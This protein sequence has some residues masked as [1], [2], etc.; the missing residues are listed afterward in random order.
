LAGYKRGE[1]VYRVEKNRREQLVPEPFEVYVPK[2]L[3]NISGIEDVLEDRCVV[4]FL[5]RCTNRAIADRE[6]DQSD[7]IWSKLRSKIYRL[8]LSHWQGVKGFYDRLNELSNVD[9]LVAFLS[10]NMPNPE[11]TDF[12]YLTAR[13][14]ELWKPI[15]A[16]AMFFDS[17]SSSSSLASRV[18]EL[19]I[20]HAK[21]KHVENVT[22]TSEMVLAETLLEMTKQPEWQDDFKA[23]KDIRDNMAAKFEDEQNWL[24][25]EWVGRALRRFGFL[26]KRRL[27]TRREI[28]LT[29][30]AVEELASRL[31]IVTDMTETTEVTV[32]RHNEEEKVLERG[33][34]PSRV[35]S[36]RTDT[37]VTVTEP[38][39]EAKLPCEVCGS[40]DAK[41]HLIP[42]KGI[43][44]LCD[45]CLENCPEKV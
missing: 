14:L 37:S 15:I 11:I 1:K 33:L 31:G 26:D 38:S 42:N 20:Q 30:K 24:S 7:V 35:T 8:Y 18:I 39:P 43:R 44:W 9:E 5:K 12:Q 21:Q 32:L 27:G 17:K 23:I 45:H 10:A 4:T 22:E 13:E 25:H 2:R 29:R 3:A 34:H 28:R 16:L 41:M 40:H 6:I 19:A 36:V